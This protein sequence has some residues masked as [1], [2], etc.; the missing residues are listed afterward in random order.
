MAV[1]NMNVV[2][3]REKVLKKSSRERLGQDRDPASKYWNRLEV[4]STSYAGVLKNSSKDEKRKEGKIIENMVNNKDFMEKLAD[5]IKGR[6]RIFV[7]EETEKVKVEIVDRIKKV[8]ENLDVKM[9]EKFNMFKEDIREDR[10][11]IKDMI[12]LIKQSEVQWVRI[13][14]PGENANEVGNLI[15]WMDD[16]DGNAVTNGD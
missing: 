8:E 16:G 6:I 5:R 2:E 15:D 9:E 12:D 10:R 14:D 4:P 1:E 11:E 3:A 13:D 7:K